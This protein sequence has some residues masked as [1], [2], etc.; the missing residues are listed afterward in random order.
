MKSLAKDEGARVQAAVDLQAEAE[1]ARLAGEAA[2]RRAR[3]RSTLRYWIPLVL[4]CL[5]AFI[6]IVF[7]P[8]HTQMASDLFHNSVEEGVLPVCVPRN[9]FDS[10]KLSEASA[11]EH[12]EKIDELVKHIKT[13]EAE[14]DTCQAASSLSQKGCKSEKN[15]FTGRLESCVSDLKL[16]EAKIVSHE[17]KIGV[18]EASNRRLQADVKAADAKV[19]KAKCFHVESTIDYKGVEYTYEELKAGKEP[20]CTVPHTPFSKGVVISTSCDK[21]VR[22]T[23]THLMSTTKGFQ[24]AYSLKSGDV[25]FGDYDKEMCI[26]QAVE[27]ETITQQY[28]GLNCVHSEVLASGLRAS[29]FG[30]FHTLPS[31]Y[32]TYVGGLVGLE[33]ASFL[34]EYIAEW[35]L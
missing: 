28:F 9:V 25:L 15:T 4:C 30:D 35:F 33:T 26:V 22:V 10:L 3:F 12:L 20:E 29:T 7:F 16:N 17:K 23:D 8:D 11:V 5:L 34:G 2:Q 24:L 14:R 1:K 27:K 31:W 6:P 21:T 18:L 32:M 13:L 19:K